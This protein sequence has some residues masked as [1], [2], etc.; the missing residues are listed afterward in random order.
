VLAA[1]PEAG[2][3]QRQLAQDLAMGTPV[4]SKHLR[5]L[6]AKGLVTILGGPGQRD[7]TYRRA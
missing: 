1:I 3:S 2:I 6:R 4:V 7:T 5:S